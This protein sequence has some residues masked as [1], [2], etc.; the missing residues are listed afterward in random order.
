MEN[1]RNYY[2]ILHIQPD[3]P[4]AI[5]KASYRTQMQKLRMH[6]DLGGD[7]W[8]ARLLNEAYQVLSNP[9][10]RSAYDREYFDA[11]GKIRESQQHPAGTGYKQAPGNP[12]DSKF[13]ADPSTCPFCRTPRPATSLLAGPG[14]CPGC[15][16]PLEVANTLRLA[17][18]SK[19]AIERFRHREAITIYLAADGDGQ[20]GMARDLS[21][22]GMQLQCRLPLRENQV[23]RISCDALSAT[24]RVTFCNR[25]MTGGLFIAGV[26]FLTLRF[27][28]RS[29]T[30]LSVSA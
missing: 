1:R 2:R 30:F 29:G 9:D 7:E 17:N 18:T 10:R 21:P 16:A 3:A 5:I 4:D 20:S 26:E 12:I 19:R 11:R 28:A 25:G 24:G 14:N 13:T 27:R 8:N 6:P 15:D 22:N 23:I